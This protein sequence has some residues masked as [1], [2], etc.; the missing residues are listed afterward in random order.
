M[1]HK[2]TCST[3]EQIT[4]NSFFFW[5]G[6]ERRRKSTS[7]G[8]K[9][10]NREVCS[11]W[12]VYNTRKS[13]LADIKYHIPYT[14]TQVEKK[15]LPSWTT[16][17]HPGHWI[18][19]SSL[20]QKGKVVSTKSRL[21]GQTRSTY[22][23]SSMYTVSRTEAAYSK[24]FFKSSF[25]MSSFSNRRAIIRNLKK[26]TNATAAMRSAKAKLPSTS[27]AQYDLG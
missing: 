8:N 27:R 17:S 14:H 6:G 22:R 1:E 23:A 18:R 21:K 11:H 24:F 5:G 26:H 15:A 25:V 10:R 7:E 12:N 16:P 19:H 3:N 20:G 4:T 13:I 2:T 9:Y